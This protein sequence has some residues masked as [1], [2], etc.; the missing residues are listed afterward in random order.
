MYNANNLPTG[1]L[2]F[3]QHQKMM[4]RKIHQQSTIF[5]GSKSTI[6]KQNN[7]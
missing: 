7:G 2:F 5:L 4:L 6:N 3:F 1:N